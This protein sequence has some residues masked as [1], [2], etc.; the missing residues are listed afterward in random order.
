MDLTVSIALETLRMAFLRTFVPHLPTGPGRPPQRPL[1][2]WKE[3]SRW[4]CTHLSSGG[5]G[6]GMLSAR[7]GGA[8][9]RGSYLEGVRQRCSGVRCLRGGKVARSWRT[10]GL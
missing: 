3:V 10:G 8:P 7:G 6:G 4:H 2:P 9:G 1:C 5:R